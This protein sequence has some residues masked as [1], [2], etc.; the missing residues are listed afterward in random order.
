MQGGAFSVDEEK[1]AAQLQYETPILP[2]PLA[3]FDDGSEEDFVR[4]IMAQVLNIKSM[5]GSL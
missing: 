2:E 1:E 5:L 3:L 4:H